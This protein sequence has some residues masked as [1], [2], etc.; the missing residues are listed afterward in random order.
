MAEPDTN[1][2]DEAWVIPLH[3]IDAP[4]G[5]FRPVVMTNDSVAHLFDDVSDDLPTIEFRPQLR[6]SA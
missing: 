1:I 2:D 3:G 6:R 5:D 4:R